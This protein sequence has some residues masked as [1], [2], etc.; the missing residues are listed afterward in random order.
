[1]TTVVKL[2]KDRRAKLYSIIITISNKH[3]PALL[4]YFCK[5]FHSR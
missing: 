1:M 2:N 3:L 4:Y 5:N